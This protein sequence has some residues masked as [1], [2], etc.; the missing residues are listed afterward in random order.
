IGLDEADGKVIAR[1]V[2]V[3]QSVDNDINQSASAPLTTEGV[4]ERQQR[5]TEA[6]E[7]IGQVFKPQK[8]SAM[9]AK[10]RSS[11]DDEWAEVES[12]VNSEGLEALDLSLLQGDEEALLTQ[13]RKH[14]V[15]DSNLENAM[16]IAK[17]SQDPSTVISAINAI[18]AADSQNSEYAL[19]EVFAAVENENA[20]KQIIS[21]IQSDSLSSSSSAWMMEQLSSTE[22]SDGVK[23]LLAKNLITAGMVENNGSTDFAQD[24]I[25]QLPFDVQKHFENNLELLKNSGR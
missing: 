12:R 9:Q 17:E 19:M 21:F 22:V 8:T 5:Q 10:N 4:V 11:V 13:L 25:D 1:A 24:M 6:A 3:W 14:Q 18:G 23:H 20:R 15:D 7:D 16:Q 2:D